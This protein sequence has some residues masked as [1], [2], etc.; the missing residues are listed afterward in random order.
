MKFYIEISHTHKMNKIETIHSDLLVSPL[1]THPLITTKDSWRQPHG[2]LGGFEKTLGHWSEGSGLLN[3]A[4]GTLHTWLLYF[5]D[6]WPHHP[7]C[8]MRRPHAYC[9][10]HTLYTT[11]F[12][13][14]AWSNLSV[15]FGTFI[16]HKTTT[17][18]HLQ[19][20]SFCKTEILY[21]NMLFKKPLNHVL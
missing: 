21:I 15:A 12:A 18:I 11:L 6:L 1:P 4:Y 5:T 2:G 17:I 9:S 16:L 13:P 14:H 20:S 10:L 8:H 19:D 7:T 3:M